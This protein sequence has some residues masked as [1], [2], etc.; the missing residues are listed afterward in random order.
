[1]R[2]EHSQVVLLP[3]QIDRLASLN[4]KGAV[5][6]FQ[7]GSTLYINTGVAK[8]VIDARGEDIDR[9]YEEPSC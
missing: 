8:F 4:S 2:S 7:D 6:I 5:G 1:M 3:E 9:P